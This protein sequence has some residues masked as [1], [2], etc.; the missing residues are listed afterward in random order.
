MMREKID[1]AIAAALR[2]C[3]GISGDTDFSVAPP[4]NPEHWDYATN[5]ALLLAKPLK[6]NPMDV[7]RTLELGMRNQ[8]LWTTEIVAPGF[9]NFLLKPGVL[10][11]GLKMILSEKETFGKVDFGKGKKARVEYVSANPTGPMH[12]GNAR[13]GPIGEVIARVLEK[14][15]YEVLREYIHNDA[16]TQVEK[17]GATLWYWYRKALGEEGE[18]PE[19]GYQGEYLGEVADAALRIEGRSLDLARLTTFG[20]DYIYRENMDVVHRMGIKFDLVR[21]E[22]ELLS[23]GKTAE[24]IEKIKQEGVTKEYDGALW[25]EVAPLDQSIDQ[26]MVSGSQDTVVVRSTGQ[27]TYFAS[28]IAYHKEKFESGYDLVI[29][30]FGSNHH[31]HVPKLQ[32]L[33]KIFGFDPTHFTV[34][35]YQYVRVKRGA[36][37]VKMSKRAGTYVTAKE[38]L[39][40][41]GADA[42]N[43]FLLMHAPGT[44]M[45][46]DLELA[47]QETQQNPVYYIQYAHARC[48]SIL[49]NAGIR[50]QE[51]GIRDFD[52]LKEK[53]EL[54]LIKKMLRIPEVIEDTAHDF[55]VQRIPH[56]ALDL[57]RAFHHFYETH[58]VITEDA[59][60]TATRLELVRATQMTLKNTLALMSIDAPDKM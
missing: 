38:V 20:L 50:N 60:L 12:I 49:K 48:A 22:S 39:D 2:V 24:A 10:H 36:E 16:G 35:L 19:G 47:K 34:V 53:E 1:M 14:S 58:R 18:F 28:D 54:D 26:Y 32:A 43:F 27:P 30:V 9:I 44:H 31:G 11:D 23:F 4:E 45:D 8:E 25:F 55:Q 6:K 59:P 40:E 51:L 57:A 56:Y 41:V 37:V 52:L 17:M 15:G 5:V 3:V 13:G 29:D 7:A 33:T 21:R 46:F 42:L